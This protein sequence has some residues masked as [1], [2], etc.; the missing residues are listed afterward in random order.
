LL[1]SASVE[2]GAAAARKCQSCHNFEEGAGNKQGPGLYDVVGR[3]IGSYEGYNYSEAMAAHR[4][5]GDV[6]SYEALDSF[7][8][9]PT[10][11]VPGT[12]MNFAGVRNDQERANILAYLGSLS[13]SPV[14]FPP[15]EAAPAE[16]ETAP[17]DAM[18]V[19][20]EGIEATPESTEA[21]PVEG[22]PVATPTETQ[23]DSPVVGTPVSETVPGETPPAEPPADEGAD[24]AGTL[25]A[26]TAN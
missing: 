8:L 5:A 25:T 7:L 6:W 15:P 14:P 16:A 20:P 4:E 10:S 26:P 22:A 18:D 11:Y 2:Q 12:K 21:V 13:A 1:A 9:S 24:E 3:V 17:A 23:T 19:T